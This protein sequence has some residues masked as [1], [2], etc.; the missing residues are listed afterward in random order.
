MW[1]G[2][3]GGLLVVAGGLLFAIAVAI[4]VGGGGVGFGRGD[5]SGLVVDAS[6]ALFGGGA[7]VLSLGGPRPQLDG[8][9]V[10]VG[11]ATL[12]VGQLGLLALSVM[13]AGSTVERLESLAPPILGAASLGSLL[14]GLGLAR[15]PGPSRAV[16]SLFLAGMVLLVLVTT[17]G[18]SGM[19]ALPPHTVLAALVMAVLG[20]IGVG[21]LAINAS[22]SAMVASV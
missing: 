22:R 3:I 17:L 2:R 5:V 19:W 6:L 1:S 9:V 21:V 11:L 13:A 7:A 12:A 18:N 14:T 10:R 8:R 4:Y 20:N 15:A 16:G